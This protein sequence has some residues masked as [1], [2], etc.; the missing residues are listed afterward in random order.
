MQLTYELPYISRSNAFYDD[1]A[2]FSSFH[3]C[4]CLNDSK[5][6]P[7]ATQK[8]QFGDNSGPLFHEQPFFLLQG[9]IRNNNGASA[10]TATTTT[11]NEN[12][13]A[14][15]TKSDTPPPA[16]TCPSRRP[17]AKKKANQ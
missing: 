5:H 7:Y 2:H 12:T 15:K 1:S 8:K 17:Q 9:S 14:G 13:A 16:V 6:L 10:T 3:F 4:R 11:T